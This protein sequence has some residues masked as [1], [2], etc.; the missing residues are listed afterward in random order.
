MVAVTANRLEMM[1]IANA[2]A[3]E[4][5][6]D[7]EVVIEAMEKAMQRAAK[8]RYG[9]D[10]DIRVIID[11]QTG[12]SDVKK[13]ITVVEE[14]EDAG[15]VTLE[16]AKALFPGEKVEIGS[17]FEEQLPPIEFN[18]VMAQNAKQVIMQELRQA[19]RSR[20]Y[21]EYK[22]RVGEIVTGIV[23]RT[24]FG[25]VIVDL[26]RAEGIIRRDQA[27]PRENLNNGERIRAYIYE[28]KEDHETRGPLIM[29][30]R[31]HPDFMKKLFTQE[32][33]EIYDGLIEI[34]NVARDP[35]SRAKIA[36]ISHDSSIDP[37]GACVGM[38]G[39]RVQAVVSELAGEKVDIIPWNE[40]PATFI[41]NAL[42]P[43]QIAK[44]V[45]DE[46]EGRIEIV[47]L[48]DQLPLA[49]GRRGQNVRL[50]HELSGWQL[51]IMT[52][53]E[54]SEKRQ[55]E[56][57]E[58]TELFQTALDVDET[59]AQLLTSEGFETIEQVAYIETV[60]LTY[61]EGFDEDTA[62]ELQSRAQEYLEEEASKFDEQRKKLGVEDD[63]AA[64]EFLTPQMVVALGENDIKTLEDFAGLI[65]DDIRGWTEIREIT[66]PTRHGM[67]KEK[68]RIRHKG[69]LDGFKID[70]EQAEAFIMQ[71][72]LAAGWVSEE[73]LAAAQA[74]EE[75]EANEGEFNV[76]DLDLSQVSLEE[77]IASTEE[78][79]GKAN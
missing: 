9:T 17:V 4:K 34:L 8:A 36:V 56:F 68:E 60:E 70:A 63:L 73:D 58:R 27:I 3:K 47:V 55:R 64:L 7:R 44:V 77:L 78:E 26:G 62:Q 57:N 74:E 31:S 15:Q 20:Q 25:N 79:A 16:D 52:E 24:E 37:V 30:S 76:D 29:L 18:R 6:I 69:V 2:L 32:V 59:I 61:I 42:Q 10:N 5:L 40:D 75:A 66:R 12:E 28:V 38:R 54:E 71:A 13:L 53:A 46:E 23:K 65:P 14:V 43:A 41:V 51:D 33:P 49:I 19:E 35:G 11:R 1:Q 67:R 48:Q 45:L 39:S 50:A 21:G 22:D 72:R